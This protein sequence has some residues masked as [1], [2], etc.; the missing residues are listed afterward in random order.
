[1]PSQPDSQTQSNKDDG[2]AYTLVA[3][4]PVLVTLT[5]GD[6][7]L[8]EF[9]NT[10][11]LAFTDVTPQGRKLTQRLSVLML[12]EGASLEDAHFTIAREVATRLT[13]QD[14][15]EAHRIFGAQARINLTQLRIEVRPNGDMALQGG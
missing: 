4:V 15:Q 12:K 9:E 2:S 5:D 11:E 14:L 6:Q 10:I 13:K 8:H 7:P 1:M 3:R